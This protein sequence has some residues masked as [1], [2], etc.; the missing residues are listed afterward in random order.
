[1]TKTQYVVTVP[2]S[3]L[4]R[5]AYNAFVAH[6]IESGMKVLE[7]HKIVLRIVNHVELLWRDASK[8]SVKPIAA[9]GVH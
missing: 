7:A 1:M 2:L 8:A 5:D 3:R 4:Q 9:K 6:A